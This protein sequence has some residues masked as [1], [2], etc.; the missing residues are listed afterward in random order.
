M[1][2]SPARV[3]GQKASVHRADMSTVTAI[4]EADTDGSV[5]LPVPEE[6]RGGKIKVVA[7]L[8]A[9][10]EESATAENGRSKVRDARGS[11]RGFP[12][13]A[14]SEAFSAEDVARIESEA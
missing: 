3:D 11:V 12:I 6:L 13:S 14:G 9:V 2:H 1:R 10:Q 7:M 4:L 5:H 8:T